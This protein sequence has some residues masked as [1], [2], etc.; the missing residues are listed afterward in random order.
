M[1]GTLR[2]NNPIGLLSTA[3]SLAAAAGALLLPLASA[4]LESALAAGLTTSPGQARVAGSPF[5][6][7]EPVIVVCSKYR[8]G[9]QI[10]TEYCKDG[11]VCGEG[12][13]CNPGPELQ[14]QIDEENRKRE[15][16]LQ[17]LQD[18]MKAADRDLMVNL[19]RLEEMADPAS[20]DW[21]RVPSPQR[22]MPVAGNVYQPAYYPARPA[23]SYV[24][25]TRVVTRRTQ[26][27]RSTIQVQNF[28]LDLMFQEQSLPA[29][30]PHKVALRQQ[31]A[32]IREAMNDRKQP[33]EEIFR[34]NTYSDA[35]PAQGANINATE[36]DDDSG[37][38]S[39]GPQAAPPEGPSSDPAVDTPPAKPKLSAADEA[40]CHF[41]SDRGR[42]GDLTGGAPIPRQCAE[43]GVTESAPQEPPPLIM[44]SHD[45]EQV[46]GIIRTFPDLLPPAPIQ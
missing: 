32:A 21:R 12:N 6:A 10:I 36:A 15:E 18:D 20:A 42:R 34:E 33:I 5:S 4:D 29:G 26:F 43:A 30:D 19:R 35:K 39:T 9:N 38:A 17:K 2:R 11:Y 7:V 16:A 3:L 45:R 14:R 44:D 25:G 37:Q 1:P 13:K 8:E 46:A 22:D 31:I 24:S 41:M 28:V 23:S 27:Y 40:W